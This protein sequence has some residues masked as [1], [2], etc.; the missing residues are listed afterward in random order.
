MTGYFNNKNYW[1]LILGGSSGI[2]WGIAQ[3][4]AKEGMNLFI[5]H[6]DR[7][8]T[9][10][11]FSDKLKTIEHTGVEVATLNIDAL[12]EEGRQKALN[13][14]EE[15][16][17]SKGKIRLLVH[18]IARGNLKPIIHQPPAHWPESDATTESHWK[19]AR[20]IE[21]IHKKTSSELSEQ[22]FQMTI[23][24]MALS[25][26]DWVKDVHAQKLFAED[27]RVIGLTS[28]GSHR[29]W[30]S[31]A[32]VGAAKATLEAISRSIALEYA[33][34]G[35]RCNIVQPGVTDTDSLSMIPG[36][37]HL[38]ANATIRNPFHRLTT[39]EDVANVV[40]LLSRDEA[41]WINGAIIPVVGGEKN[42]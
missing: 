39:P 33:P 17:A 4:M 23:Q 15:K 10:A 3:K 6:R 12:R 20:D 8:K 7:K 18:S 25:L 21:A 26:L 9:A 14:L 36:S 40:Y 37:E 27:A 5:V 34:F 38:K 31:Y 35:I 2:G 29:A 11:V 19:I 13:L 42:R 28:E 30:R 32:A 24:A 41:A 22:D 1:A 16:M